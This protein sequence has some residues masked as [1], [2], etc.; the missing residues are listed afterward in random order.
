MHGLWWNI[1]ENDEE[2]NPM[3]YIHR[4]YKERH[5]VYVHERKRSLPEVPDDRR[6]L[7]NYK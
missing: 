6:H 7:I 3:Y 5:S 1:K 2:S 4:I